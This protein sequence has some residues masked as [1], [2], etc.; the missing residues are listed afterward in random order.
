MA[1]TWVRLKKNLCGAVGNDENVVAGGSAS[2]SGTPGQVLQLPGTLA[3]TLIAASAAVA[4]SSTDVS[5]D[6]NN[7]NSGYQQSRTST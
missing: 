6:W 3:T 4:C 7:L 5:Q 2:F 1:M